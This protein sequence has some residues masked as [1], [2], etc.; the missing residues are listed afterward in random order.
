MKNKKQSGI[1]LDEYEQEIE[2]ALPDQLDELSVT[3][4]LEEEIAFSRQ[5]AAN[6]LRKD[7]K[8]NIRLSQFDLEGLKRLAV[9]EG[10]PYQTLI[11]S[12]LHKYVTHYLNEA[13]NRR[14]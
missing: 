7:A 5:A 4:N 13:S 1:H 2:D 11:S 3:D 8:I 10:L 9:R 6:Y 14:D 12:I